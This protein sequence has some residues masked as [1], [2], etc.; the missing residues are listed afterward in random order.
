MYDGGH[1]GQNRCEER[2]NG[3]Y[4]PMTYYLI[5]DIRWPALI[6]RNRL[7][8]Q[9]HVELTPKNPLGMFFCRYFLFSKIFSQVCTLQKKVC[10]M[11]KTQSLK[12]LVYIWMW[13][14]QM[15]RVSVLFADDNWNRPCSLDLFIPRERSFHL[16]EQGDQKG[17][18]WV[19]QLS[20]HIQN[21]CCGVE[22][23]T[24]TYMQKG[25][26]SK[27][28][29]SKFTCDSERNNWWDAANT[30]ETK[31]KMLSYTCTKL[32][33]ILFIIGKVTIGIHAV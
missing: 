26:M 16:W 32:Y 27:R 31:V 9:D 10:I 12:C 23:L 18:W 4:R 2:G 19:G 3:N 22:R 20:V 1:R 33:C 29:Y 17:H 30:A 8:C 24:G 7:R 25:L 15:K 28:I 14:I 5:S 21:V 6:K 11:T 13:E